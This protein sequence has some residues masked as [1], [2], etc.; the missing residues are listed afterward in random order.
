M[1]LYPLSIIGKGFGI[2]CPT[3]IVSSANDIVL[4]RWILVWQD[5]FLSLTYDRPPNLPAR[6]CKPPYSS[7]SENGRSYAES[8]FNI[9]DIILDLS[10]V[11][12]YGTG[13]EGI[14][15]ASW[16]CKTKLE[17]VLQDSTP[18]LTSKTS[19]TTLRQH[20]ERLALAIHVGYAI[21][22]LCYSYLDDNS[23]ITPE[24]E[25]LCLDCAWRA[26]QVVESFLDMRR[27]SA[28]LCRSW[29]FVHNA[30]SCAILLKKL[31]C[32]ELLQD[33]PQ[34]VEAL[35]KKLTT[36]LENDKRESSWRDDD[37]N[38]RYFGPYTRAL[39]ALKDQ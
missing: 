12:N 18:Y 35:I 26:V 1:L 6:R 3:D 14:L 27:L 38:M 19:C 13:R 29:A 24:Q 30:V 33:R 32:L 20:L 7:A 5:T 25:S 21:S 34:H 11:D 39:A 17:H 4:S 9:C 10:R 28:N 2:S 37:S 15:Q 36:V 31:N 22:R 16:S 23:E 8:I